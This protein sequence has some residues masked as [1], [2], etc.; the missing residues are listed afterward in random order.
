ME[1]DIQEK[2]MRIISRG[3]RGTAVVSDPEKVQISKE[4][5]DWKST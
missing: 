3:E 5:G 2:Q 1:N 4:L